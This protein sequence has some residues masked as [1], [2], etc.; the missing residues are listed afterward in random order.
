MCSRAYASL[1]NLGLMYKHATLGTEKDEPKAW[2]YFN[3][4]VAHGYHYAQYEMGLLCEEGW[5]AAGLEKDD[6]KAFE[7]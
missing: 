6:R 2:G 3:S 7:W 5:P 4:S 1:N